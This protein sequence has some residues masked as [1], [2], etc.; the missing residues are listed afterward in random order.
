MAD[1]VGQYVAGY[2]YYSWL[3]PFGATVILTVAD[4][5]E[6]K[7]FVVEPSGAYWASLLR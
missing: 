3:R 1:R 2:T 7:M 6:A 5:E 4:Q